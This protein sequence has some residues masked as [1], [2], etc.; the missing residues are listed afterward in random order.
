MFKS[1]QTSLTQKEGAGWPSTLVNDD[2][3]H[4]TREMVTAGRQVTKD[5]VASSLRLSSLWTT[6][7]SFERS[8]ICLNM[9]VRDMVQ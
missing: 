9:D 7:A 3:F 5:K 2:N 8:S 1:G 6:Q 4:R